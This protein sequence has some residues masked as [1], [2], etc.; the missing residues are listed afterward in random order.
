[1]G[2]SEN[3]CGA[4]KSRGSLTPLLASQELI[5]HFY[6]K[7]G[8]TNVIKLGEK[9][10][11]KDSLFNY[12]WLTPALHSWLTLGRKRE[13]NL[14]NLLTKE[15]SH[16]RVKDLFLL[17]ANESQIFFPIYRSVC[18]G[19]WG[20]QEQAERSTE[21]LS[22]GTRPR[23]SV[24]THLVQHLGLHSKQH[25]SLKLFLFLLL[26]LPFLSLF[27]DIFFVLISLMRSKNTWGGEEKAISWCNEAVWPSRICGHILKHQAK[28]ILRN[29]GPSKTKG[30]KQR[31]T[32]NIKSIFWFYK[33]DISAHITRTEASRCSCIQWLTGEW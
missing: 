11:N 9:R 26:F 31:R 12:T 20:A 8:D 23:S 1:M 22:Q 6:F 19:G 10:R 24:A 25:L 27:S 17:P 21:V 7:E 14:C 18:E 3:Y 4:D 32:I 29:H 5:R 13:I 30:L 33:G 28:C 16:G 15:P 2:V